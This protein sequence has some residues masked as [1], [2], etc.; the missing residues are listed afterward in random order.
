[1]A[2]FGTMYDMSIF[3]FH[4]K[5]GDEMIADE[6][7]SDLPDLAAVREEALQCA[8]EILAG[9]IRTGETAVPDAIVVLDEKGRT[10]DSLRLAAVLPPSL[11]AMIREP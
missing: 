6:E 1:M 8:R 9:A 11:R 3:F 2:R 5:Q 4:L 7:G 10:V